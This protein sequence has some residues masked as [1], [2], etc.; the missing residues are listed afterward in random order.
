MLVVKRRRTLGCLRE[1]ALRPAPVAEQVNAVDVVIRDRHEILEKRL[2]R[3]VRLEV[4]EVP[5]P[6]AGQGAAGRVDQACTGHARFQVAA[7]G[8]HLQAWIQFA[9]AARRLQKRQADAREGPVRGRYGD[10]VE[11]LR[12]RRCQEARKAYPA[13]RIVA[14]HGAV[15]P[16]QAA[17]ADDAAEQHQ[18]HVGIILVDGI[19]EVKGVEFVGIAEHQH[20]DR[21][22][23]TA[24]R[25]AAAQVAGRARI[26]KARVL[27]GIDRRHGQLLARIAPG[28]AVPE[29]GA[30]QGQGQEQ[31]EGG[32]DT[33]KASVGERRA[34]TRVAGAGI[35]APLDTGVQQPG[36]EQHRGAEQHLLRRR[37]VTAEAVAVQRHDGPVDE[38]QRVG[39]L[40]EPGRHGMPQQVTQYAARR[41]GR[42]PEQGQGR[43]ERGR[44]GSPAGVQRVTVEKQHAGDDQQQSHGQARPREQRRVAGPQAACGGREE[45]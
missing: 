15:I 36:E 41:R 42:G 28:P 1:T 8:Q 25:R 9:Q 21:R 10:H 16:A 3:R 39:H 20:L 30:A 26:A 6:C 40:A 7:E 19:E 27:A 34:R 37:Q 14:A 32:D 12:Q 31:H 43:T 45:R 13:L 24:I 35:E 23:G 44:Q 17:A 4:L 33:R 22:V 29:P 38:I 18:G 5:G 2:R 11:A